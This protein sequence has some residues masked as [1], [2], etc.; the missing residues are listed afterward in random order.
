MTQPIFF[1]RLEALILFIAVA[2]QY[3]FLGGTIGLFLL[4]FFAPDVII[5]GYFVNK[6]VGAAF[7]NIG[8]SFTLPISFTTLGLVN[9]N[10]TLQL[11]GLIWLAHIGFDRAL[12]FG[13]KEETNFFHTHLGMI[14]KHKK[15]SA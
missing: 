12:G 15:D 3:H 1:Q 4:L 6:K 7:Y 9:A 13:L 14:G 10:H 2:M 8:H 5:L 11:I